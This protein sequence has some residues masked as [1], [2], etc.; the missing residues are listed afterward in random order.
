MVLDIIYNPLAGGV[1]KMADNLAKLVKHLN[2]RGVEFRLHKT[3]YEKHAV[4]L[5]QNA[6]KNGATTIIS[7]GGDGTNN[8]VLNGLSNFENITFGIIPCGT[9]NDFATHAKIPLDVTKAADVI[10]DNPAVFTDYIQLPTVRALNVVGIG[11]DVDVL[12]RY[13]ALKKKTKAGYYKCLIKS[14]L[15]YK[16]KNIS[17]QING[18][19]KCSKAFI[20]AVANASMFGGGITISPD[21]NENDGKLNLVTVDEIKGLKLIGALLKLNSGKL[22]ELKQTHC[23]LIEE[24]SIDCDK[25]TIVNVDG[26]LYKNIPFDAKIVHNQLRLHKC[27]ADCHTTIFA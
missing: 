1:K 5:T 16:C 15:S 12:T 26:E 9:G 10:L 23:A 6:I 7:M 2:E 19:K 3:E 17:Y 20:A 4:L 25:D 13:Q 18:E 27:V 8:E 22:N 11:I 21:A 14:L 24:I